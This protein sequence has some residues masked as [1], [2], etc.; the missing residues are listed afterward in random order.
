MA[1]QRIF[2]RGTDYETYFHT[3]NLVLAHKFRWNI[4][5]HT[6]YRGLPWQGLAC[7]GNLPNATA[8]FET[9]RRASGRNCGLRVATW[10]SGHH[11]GFGT[12][13]RASGRHGGFRMSRRASGHHGGL[14]DATAGFGT[15]RRAS[16][17]H[18]EIQDV[19]TGFGA[20]RRASGRHGG[21][22]NALACSG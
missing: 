18:G 11:G 4:Y 9:P 15:P 7:H 2:L 6:E 16:G 12:P 14:R 21:L 5:K 1:Q 22:R 17:R 20:P 10:V 19:T 8:G 3:I 13:R